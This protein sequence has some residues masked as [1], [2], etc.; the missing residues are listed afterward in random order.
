MKFDLQNIKCMQNTVWAELH[1]HV[2]VPTG[3]AKERMAA[4][5]CRHRWLGDVSAS[6]ASWLQTLLARRQ[7]RSL[8]CA[9]SS[10]VLFPKLSASS[11]GWPRSCMSEGIGTISMPIT[12]SLCWP[13]QGS[14]QLKRCLTISLSVALPGMLLFTGIAL[15]V[16]VWNTYLISRCKE[17]ARRRRECEDRSMR[18]FSVHSYTNVLHN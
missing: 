15:F 8:S 5:D 17:W 16:I 2:E 9:F 12:S 6:K 18:R 1:V 13:G 14:P 10:F 3:L 7:A 4:W 11:P